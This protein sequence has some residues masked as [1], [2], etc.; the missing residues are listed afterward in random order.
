MEDAIAKTSTTEST[1]K[2]ESETEVK[3]LQETIDSLKN[4]V[5]E[6]HS[7]LLEAAILNNKYVQTIQDH[8]KQI[9]QLKKPPL[10]ICSVVELFDNMALLRQHGSNQENI[11]R[12]PDEIIPEIEAG[13]RVA[14][15]NNLAI[16][17]VLSRSV[18]VRARVME[19]IEAPD[20]DYDMIGGLHRQIEE[21]IEVL[22]LPLTSPELF[23]EVGIEPPNGILL[24]GPPGTG[25]TLIAKAVAHRA[26]AT[27]IRMSGTELVQK[28]IGEGARLVRDVFNIAREKAPSIVFIDEIDAV[29]SRRTYEGTTGSSEVN[30]TMVQ[31]L[32]E[33]DGFDKRGHVKI[34]AATNRIDLLDP[35]L[36]RPGRFDR[37]I[38]VPRPDAKGRWE[39]FKIHSRNMKLDNVDFEELAEMTE[40]LSGADLKAIVTE[41]GMFVIRR[42][43][44]AVTMEDFKK[45]YDKMIIKEK[46]EEVA[47][48]F[49]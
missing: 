36:L 17:K 41:A 34:V 20:I 37:I 24:Y 44:K 38:E 7:R 31:L 23:T 26:K 18:D 10:F 49:V 40:G 4:Q 42:K 32:S 3:E 16:V 19:L 35:A 30:R 27:F 29:G 28:Y 21:V 39:I 22:E 11:T 33:L 6:M 48:M 46:K 1:I 2:K 25:K 13:A 43:G 14:V 12:I 15:T 8:Q 45:A 9:E 5:K 47:G